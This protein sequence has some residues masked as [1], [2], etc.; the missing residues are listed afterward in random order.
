MRALKIP[1][2][3]G[4]RAARRRSARRGA[5]V[6][7]PECCQ[8]EPILG[9]CCLPDGSCI[10]STAVQCGAA[11]G[12]W[13]GP[14]TGCEPNPCDQPPPPNP[15]CC[16]TPGI[17]CWEACGVVS[18]RLEWDLTVSITECCDV[19]QPATLV[20]CGTLPFVGFVTRDT[21]VNCGP[22]EIGR[23]GS[24]NLSLNGGTT[25]QFNCG[26]VCADNNP[27]RNCQVS[28]AAVATFTQFGVQMRLTLNGCNIAGIT[29]FNDTSPGCA[30][31]FRSVSGS[32]PAD[33]QCGIFPNNIAFS[34]MSWSGTVTATATNRFPC[35]AAALG[36]AREIVERREVGG[37]VLVP[38]EASGGGVPCG[39][40]GG[41]AL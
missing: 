10:S 33:F 41:R 18:M 5:T 20:S 29:L 7:C 38:R 23:C 30:S 35:N 27:N 26:S 14:D 8:P 9:A 37:S 28:V 19:G 15:D 11:G 24:P 6:D 1:F 39:G 40:C 34:R 17:T 2:G 32:T 31:G 12:V 3:A 36:I 4:F 16:N 25:R 21:P 13:Q 22:G